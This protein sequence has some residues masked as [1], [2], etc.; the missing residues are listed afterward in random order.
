MIPALGVVVFAAMLVEAEISRR[1]DVRLRAA[2]ALEPPGDVYA[3]MQV[4][5]PGVFL[6]M[7]AEGFWREARLDGLAVAGL[8]VFGAAKGLKYWAIA[9]LGERWTFR[10]LVPPG[11]ACIRRGP[12]RWLSHPNYLA[13]GGEI[14]GCALTSHAFVTGPLAFA[15][16]GTLM[17]QRIKIEEAALGE[18]RITTP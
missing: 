13:V 2:G 14:V 11:S 8:A 17:L 15:L 3:A 9:S 1:H 12:Y 16:F 7:L 4:A 5:Y 18:G 6:I 10:V